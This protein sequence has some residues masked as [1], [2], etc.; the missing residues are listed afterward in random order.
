MGHVADALRRARAGSD[1][2]PD[3]AIGRPATVRY[4][5]A[6]RAAIPWNIKDSDDDV[7]RWSP[8]AGGTGEAIKTAAPPVA[9]HFHVDPDRTPRPTGNLG[10]RLVASPAVP[11]AVREE[12]NRLAATLRQ[13]QLE[14]GLKAVML[15]SAVPDEGKTLTAINLALTLSGSYGRRVLLIDADLRR[16]SVHEALGVAPIPGLGDSLKDASFPVVR[17]RAGLYLL[18]AGRAVTHPMTTLTSTEMHALVEAS[19]HEF[20]WIVLDTPPIGVLPDARLLAS[21][22]DGALLVARAGQTEY[23]IVQQ[24]ADTIGPDRILGLVLNRTAERALPAR[25]YYDHYRGKTE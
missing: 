23:E 2:A 1:A 8:A 14:R 7:E 12:Y 9:G 3:E 25:H 10:E 11:P 22:V 19:R 18:T 17:V 6:G 15:T 16:P 20:D 4:P 21:M 5:T 13:A 24:A